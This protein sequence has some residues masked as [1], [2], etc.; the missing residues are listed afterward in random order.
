MSKA[1]TRES[2]EDGLAELPEREVS[3]YPNLVTPEGRAAIDREID[4]HSGSPLSAPA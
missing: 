2:D 4:R 3:S 1:F